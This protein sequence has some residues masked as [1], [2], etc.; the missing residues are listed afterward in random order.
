MEK[1][2]I[3][4]HLPS[5][6]RSSETVDRLAHVYWFEASQ[7]GCAQF[8]Q[9]MFQRK[10]NGEGVFRLS[11]FAEATIES[12]SCHF[13]SLLSRRF[14]NQF[15]FESS[16]A[17]FA[18]NQFAGK[19]EKNIDSAFVSALEISITSPSIVFRFSPYRHACVTFAPIASDLSQIE[20]GNR[21]K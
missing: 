12:N 8:I 21:R 10:I 3:F 18:P 16:R 11:K 14:I 6:L 4:L 7:L 15:Q 20:D 1:I 9:E 13:V 5:A 19:C 2:V 17:H